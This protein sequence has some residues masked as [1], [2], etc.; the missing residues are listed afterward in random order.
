[1]ERMQDNLG[2]PGPAGKQKESPGTKQRRWMQNLPEAGGD[3]NVQL[4]SPGAHLTEPRRTQPTEPTEEWPGNPQEER[5]CVS[6]CVD[7]R[8][9]AILYTSLSHWNCLI[10]QKYFSAFHGPG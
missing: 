4:P 1:M 5:V 3:L 10:Y 6:V 8:A 7:A 2:R 9:H